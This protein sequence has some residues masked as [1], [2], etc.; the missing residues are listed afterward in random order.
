MYSTCALSPQEND[1]MLQR[2]VKKFGKE[3][4]QGFEFLE[5]KPDLTQISKC[6]SFTLPQWEKTQFGYQ[7]L[8]DKSNGAGPIYLS[9]IH[10]NS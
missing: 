7:I 4:S 8:P 5:P 2:L 6:A 9:L 3:G 1:L 10:K